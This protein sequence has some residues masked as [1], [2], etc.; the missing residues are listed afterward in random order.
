MIKE[1]Q[2]TE[3]KCLGCWV[4]LGSQPS[5]PPSIPGN[6]TD[7]PNESVT[8]TLSRHFCTSC[9]SHMGDVGH[10]RRRK[11]GINLQDYCLWKPRSINLIQF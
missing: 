9:M 6:W 8:V 1:R 7:L 5:G 10:A 11:A 4:L 2:V 3:V